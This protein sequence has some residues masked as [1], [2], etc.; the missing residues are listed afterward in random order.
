[1]VVEHLLDQPLW[2]NELKHLGL[3]SK[4]LHRR[5]ITAAKLA[6]EIRAVLATPAMG[7]KAQQLAES[8][9]KEDGV[10]RAVELIEKRFK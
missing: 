3:T 10:G 1:V 5:S 4:V 2:G 7:Q 6:K 9:Q 8:M